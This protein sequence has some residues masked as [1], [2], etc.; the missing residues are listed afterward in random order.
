M[1]ESKKLRDLQEIL[2]LYNLVNTVTSPTRVTKN[3]TSLI[4]EII[5]NKEITRD[6]AIVIDLGYSDHMAQVLKL[7][8]KNCYTDGIL[9]LHENT[10]I[11]M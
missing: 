7:P 10:L 8:I 4:D 6:T 9:L 1:Q 2:S 11:K 5:T 3:S